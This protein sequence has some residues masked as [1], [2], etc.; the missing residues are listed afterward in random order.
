[1]SKKT[2]PRSPIANYA[3]TEIN[4]V[5]IITDYV[6]R[7][8]LDADYQREKVWSREAQEKLVDSIIKNIDIP[9]I[10]LARVK[11]SENFDFE[12]MMESKGWRRY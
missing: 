12:C 11:D 3:R 7:I 4:S 6:Y 1:V 9:K 8:D 2:C 10:Y 5:R